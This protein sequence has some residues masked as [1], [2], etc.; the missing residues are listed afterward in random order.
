MDRHVLY[1]TIDAMPKR[2]LKESMPTGRRSNQPLS[3]RRW[4][5]TDRDVEKQI[6]QYRVECPNGCQSY[7][8]DIKDWDD[9]F[10]DN[11]EESLNDCSRCSHKLT[12]HRRA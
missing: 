8:L 5:M 10:E 9:M 2:T 12:Y 6:R 3:T 7:G 11:L 1:S 4:R